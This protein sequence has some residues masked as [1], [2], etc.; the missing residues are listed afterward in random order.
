MLSHDPV[1]V[2]PLLIDQKSRFDP[3]NPFYEHGEV[4]SFLARRGPNGEIV[5]RISAVVNH[6][7][8]RHHQDQVGFFGYFDCVDSTDVARA[9]FDHAGRFLKDRGLTSMRGPANLSVNDEIGMLIEGFD[10]PPVIMM[11][12]NPPYYNRL[13]EECGFIKA[14]DLLAYSLAADQFTERVTSLGEKLEKR[15]KLRIRPFRK[16]DFWNEVN[17]VLGIYR[18]AWEDNWGNVPM[19]DREIKALAESL[20]LIYDPRLIFFVET[21]DGKPVGFC[22]ALPDINPLIKKINGRLL[23]TG[24]FTLLNGRKKLNRARVLL[25]GVLPEYRGRG[26]DTVMYLR[27]Y[28]SGYEA[29]YRWAEISWILEDN[30]LMNDAAVAIGAV[31]YKKWRMWEKPL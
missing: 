12:H 30:R 25:M 18:I 24:I 20:K 16:N 10:T 1:W 31:P 14:K 5:G 7:H 28:K 13:V 4:E 29:G 17:K 8:N 26:I 6:A 9:L 27:I 21:E 22:L 3:K 23:P 15:L 2:P 19:T 11:T